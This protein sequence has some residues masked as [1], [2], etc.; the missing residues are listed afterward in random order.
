MDGWKRDRSGT[1]NKGLAGVGTHFK[2]SKLLLED[3]MGTGGLDEAGLVSLLLGI[4][5]AEAK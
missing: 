1:G 5:M 2:P 3:G 4:I